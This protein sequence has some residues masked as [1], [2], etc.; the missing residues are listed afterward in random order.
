MSRI[1][2]H[3][4]LHLK[5]LIADEIALHG[6][7]CSLNH[8]DI[9]LITDMSYL[10][11][12]SKFNGDISKWDTSN[13]SNMGGMF[14]KSSF[15]SDISNWNVSNVESMH[16]MFHESVFNGDISKWD[17]SNIENM[18]YIFAHTKYNQ[19]LTNWK[20][21]KLDIHH[22]FSFVDI[23]KPYW[24]YYENLNERKLAIDNYIEKKALKEKLNIKLDSKI[25]T[26][27][28]KL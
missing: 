28:N 24:A 1:I 21:Y 4:K 27:K 14:Y 23:V 11:H 26:N 10:F 20:P 13:V 15:N 25:K 17:V 5:S 16:G 12:T 22:I 3:D 18:R 2:A 8:I 9:S 6:N 7:A 19:D